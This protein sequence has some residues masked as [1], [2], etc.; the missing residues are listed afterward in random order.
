M[1]VRG[2]AAVAAR[3]AVHVELAEALRVGPGRL[4]APD[5]RALVVARGA[6]AVEA[7]AAGAGAPVLVEDVRRALRGVSVAHLGEVA[8]VGGAAADCVGRKEL[9]H[10]EEETFWRKFSI[11]QFSGFC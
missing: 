4:P 10:E 6:A 9:Q 8:L 1:A 7:V 3:R 11:L 2:P 5:A